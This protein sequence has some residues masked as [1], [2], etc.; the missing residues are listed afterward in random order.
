[1]NEDQITKTIGALCK[2]CAF[3]LLDEDKLSMVGGGG[4]E[5]E[6]YVEGYEPRYIG[7]LFD[8]GENDEF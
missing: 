2:S 1:M 7:F 3:K 4:L 5:P 8:N 6:F